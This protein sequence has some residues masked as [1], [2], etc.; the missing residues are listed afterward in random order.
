[1]GLRKLSTNTYDDRVQLV[2]DLCTAIENDPRSVEEIAD[3]AEVVPSTIYFWLNGDTY[4]PRINTMSKVATALGYVFVL[5]KAKS[6][7]VRRIK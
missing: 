5:R 2:E 4:A 3:E 1:M 6:G 7:N